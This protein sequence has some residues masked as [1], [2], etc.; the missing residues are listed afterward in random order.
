MDRI[1]FCANIK[2][3]RLSENH[4]QT[5]ITVKRNP[6]LGYHFILGL[7]ITEVPPAQLHS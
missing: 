1:G 2:Q 7:E 6:M 3:E 4:M 5:W